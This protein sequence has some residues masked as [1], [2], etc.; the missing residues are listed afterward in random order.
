MIKELDHFYQA[1]STFLSQQTL[2][3]ELIQNP[4]YEQLQEIMKK[5]QK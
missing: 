2:Q 1:I 5:V 4:T 3:W